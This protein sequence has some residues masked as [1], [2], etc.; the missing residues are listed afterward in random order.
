MNAIH[1]NYLENILELISSY[2]PAIK[3]ELLRYHPFEI[4][5]AITSLNH[6]KFV[7]LMELLAPI[8][9]ANIIAH[10]EG[11]DL[12]RIFSMMPNNYA[13]QV[14]E[15]M[16]VDDASAILNELDNKT[17]YLP[18]IDKEKR[19]SITKHLNYPKDSVGSIMNPS[20][21]EVSA[22]DRAKDATKYVMK[23]AKNFEFINY[24]YALDNNQLVGTISL[25][26]LI[27][28]RADDLISDVMTDAPKRISVD[29]NK[30]DAAEV[31]RQYDF[32]ALPVVDEN[33]TMLG[34]IT[35]DD[36]MDVI[37]EA[38]TEDYAKFAGVLTSELSHEKDTVW[39]TFLKRIPWLLILLVIN[40]F[41]PAITGKYEGVLAILPILAIFLPLLLGM[42][43]NAGTQSLAITVRLIET[44]QLKDR[45]DKLST[46]LK[47]LIVGIVNGLIVGVIM[48]LL[49]IIILLISQ[50]HIDASNLP[51]AGI[52]SL[53]VIIIM[54][55]STVNGVLIPLI[56]VAFKIDAA[57]ASGP[58]ITTIN[59]ISALLIYFSLASFLI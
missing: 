27:L 3:E 28:A 15:E 9:M 34:I 24:I 50:G 21:L 37:T 43:G 42:A 36:V 51:I 8:E 57:A 20:F 48:F 47:E 41:L 32:T 39:S 6:L 18:L 59:D 19:I 13:V 12:E 40:L 56:M 35:V 49:S 10:L 16:E 54:I 26:D 11:E 4:A 52:V 22:K 55:V 5:E 58:F 14:L 17:V 38:A 53:S 23:N 31:F 45:R 46:F 25:K 44:R 7:F 29:S 2:D 33:N 1:E 30:E